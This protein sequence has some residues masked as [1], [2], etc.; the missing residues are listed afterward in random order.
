MPPTISTAVFVRTMPT[1]KEEIKSNPRKN[2]IEKQK[3]NDV[4]TP[5]SP[6]ITAVNFAFTNSL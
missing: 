2:I 6:M 5:N 1:N 4:I 3:T